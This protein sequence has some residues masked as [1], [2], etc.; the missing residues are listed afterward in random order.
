MAID[1]IGVRCFDKDPPLVILSKALIQSSLRL[2]SSLA[3]LASVRLPG[4]RIEGILSLK[5][6]FGPALLH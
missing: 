3:I 2:S 1:L 4:M 5:L 6:A